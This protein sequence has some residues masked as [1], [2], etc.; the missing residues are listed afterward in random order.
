MKLFKKK[1]NHDRLT[2]VVRY[3]TLAS[4]AVGVL[5]SLPDVRRYVKISTM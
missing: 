3:L 2:Q 1:K 5:I 4:I